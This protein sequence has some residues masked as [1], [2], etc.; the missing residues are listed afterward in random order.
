MT[1]S[2]KTLSQFSRRARRKTLETASLTSRPGKGRENIILRGIEKHLEDKAVTG[3]SQNG[4]M[5]AKPCLSN[6]ISSHDKIV[7]SGEAR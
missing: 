3:H 2:W 1:G 4:F 5:R 6:P 7:G